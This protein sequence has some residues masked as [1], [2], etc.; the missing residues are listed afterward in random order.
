MDIVDLCARGITMPYK[1][2]KSVTRNPA[3]EEPGLSAFIEISSF[4]IFGNILP[5]HA[6]TGLAPFHIE[7]KISMVLSSTNEPRIWLR[8]G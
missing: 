2:P 1:K 7:K 5:I 3:I 8:K 6:W 4:T